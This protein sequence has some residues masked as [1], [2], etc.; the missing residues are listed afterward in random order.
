M[1]CKCRKKLEKQKKKCV[2][3]EK[4][5]AQIRIFAPVFQI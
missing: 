4:I 1:N 2:I 5:I 3:L